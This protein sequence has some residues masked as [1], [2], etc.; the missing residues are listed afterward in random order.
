MVKSKSD[1]AKSDYLFIQDW[2]RGPWS[3]GLRLSGSD[4]MRG[5]SARSGEDRPQM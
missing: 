2:R 4:G 5:D 1:Y 3:G